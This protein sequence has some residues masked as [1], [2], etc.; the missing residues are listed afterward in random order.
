M[1]VSKS[2]FISYRRSHVYTALAVYK[3]LREHGYDVFFDYESIDSGAFDRII[4]NQIAARAHF[5]VILTPGALVRCAE[6]GDWLRHEIEYAIDQK[7]NIIPLFFENFEFAHEQEHLTGK[8][9]LLPRYNAFDIPKSVIYFD[10]AMQNLRDRFLNQ[11][12]QGILHPVSAADASII[13]EKIAMTDKLIDPRVIEE[14]LAR[15]LKYF[16]QHNYDAAIQ[17]FTEVIWLQPRLAK[18][19][20]YRATCRIMKQD[21][22]EALFDANEAIRLEP[23]NARAYS[24]RGVAYYW[25]RNFDQA[26]KDFNKAIHLDPK[27]RKPLSSQLAEFYFMRGSLYRGREQYPEAIEDYEN[28]VKFKPNFTE[29]YYQR[30]LMYRKLNKLALAIKDFSSV[31]LLKADHVEAYYNRGMTYQKQGDLIAA[32]HDYEQYVRLGGENATT[33]RQWVSEN[34]KQIKK[35]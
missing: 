3:N 18:M 25:L 14:Y 21:Y 9:A 33:V 13:R 30:G 8:L 26:I 32:N 7:R 11:P 20:V 27:L 5:I 34:L 35:P 17:Q 28:A 4:L 23:N 12:L 1:T 15:G 29:A 2:V 10:V 6:P 24:E 31:V 16:K 19:Y 22:E